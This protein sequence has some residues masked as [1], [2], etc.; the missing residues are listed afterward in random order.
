[1]KVMACKNFYLVKTEEKSDLS[2]LQLEM[3][4]DD[5]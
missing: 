4:L 5:T 1:M 2:S 3:R